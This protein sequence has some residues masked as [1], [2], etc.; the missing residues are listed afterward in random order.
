MKSSFQIIAS[1]CLLAAPLMGLSQG[2]LIDAPLPHS[3]GQSVSPSFEGWYPNA[4]GSFSLVFGYFNRNYEEHLSIPIGENNRFEPGPED[5]GQPEFFYPRRHTGVFAIEVPAEFGDQQLTWRLNSG[6]ESI[7]IPGHLRP[8]WEITA[9]EEI[10]S[11]NTPPLVRFSSNGE[12]GQGPMGVYSP[13]ITTTAGTNTEL[14][15]WSVDDGVKKS[16]SV[17]QAARN[18]LVLGK[19][20]GTGKV[21]FADETPDLVNGKATTTATFDMPGEYVLRV[22]A[23]DDSGG[24]AFI[25]AGGFF[26]CWTNGYIKLNVE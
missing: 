20:R 18:G 2:N 17:G 14:T 26:C 1:I 22:L 7:A 13:T 3:K 6:S 25:M 8:E 15:I 12:P 23:W 11:G 24:Q 16:R 4:D 5:R 10:T 19:Y 9:L 21:E